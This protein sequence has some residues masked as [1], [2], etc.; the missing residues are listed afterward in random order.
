MKD[1]MNQRRWNSR[2]AR[3][4]SRALIRSGAAA[5]ECAIVLPIAVFI[6][7]GIA[8]LGQG[9]N[10]STMLSA[11]VREAG[12][13]ACMD[14]KEHVPPNMTPNQKIVQDV[15]RVLMAAGVP[16]NAITVQLTH[17]DGNRV[18]QSFDLN[19]PSNYQK[20]FRLEVSVPYNQISSYPLRMLVNRTIT[21]SIVMRRGRVATISN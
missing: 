15:K 14:F 9:L 11:S 18:G 3:R 1:T 10:A 8:E 21:S 17:A 12:R 4:G 16:E 6:F 2:F 20:L 13:L 19:D 7:L 5:V